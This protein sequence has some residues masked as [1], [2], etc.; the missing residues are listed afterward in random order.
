MLAL[1]NGVIACMS[2]D[3]YEEQ[4]SSIWSRVLR[5]YDPQENMLSTYKLNPSRHSF[6]TALPDHRMAIF[7]GTL[8][9]LPY[10]HKHFKNK[11]IEE[12]SGNKHEDHCRIC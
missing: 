5:F 8:S 7:D 9:I 11:V 3:K 12:K 1:P 2:G 4:H 10:A 6:F